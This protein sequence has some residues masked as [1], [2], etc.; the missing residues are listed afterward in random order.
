MKMTHAAKGRYRR[1]VRQKRKR[2]NTLQRKANSQFTGFSNSSHQ[3]QGQQQ[4]DQQQ[5]QQQQQQQEQHNDNNEP[6]NNDQLANKNTQ[7]AVQHS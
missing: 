7:M 1:D 2:Q 4:V 6:K 3:Q 5:Q